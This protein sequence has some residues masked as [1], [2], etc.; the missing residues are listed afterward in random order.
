M[1]NKEKTG[2]VEPRK[3][4]NKAVQNRVIKRFTMLAKELHPN[5][6]RIPNALTPP[7]DKPENEKR[8]K[9]WKKKYDRFPTKSTIRYFAEPIE[10]T[11][12]RSSNVRDDNGD[13]N[14]KDSLKY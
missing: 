2:G 7:A 1:K 8:I 5:L 3:K 13:E 10:F 12:F 6:K 11:D 14:P 9:E 4:V